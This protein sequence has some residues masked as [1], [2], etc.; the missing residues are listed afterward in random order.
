MQKAVSGDEDW[1]RR[2]GTG[3]ELIVGFLFT[4]HRTGPKIPLESD[5]LRL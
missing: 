5:T 1:W 3:K 2:N 4:P